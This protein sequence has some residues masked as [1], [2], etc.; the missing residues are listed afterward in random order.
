VITAK[1][2][3]EKSIPVAE[4][5]FFFKLSVLDLSAYSPRQAITVAQSGILKHIVTGESDER[6]FY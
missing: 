5:A 3:T 1:L 6:M 4:G 2:R